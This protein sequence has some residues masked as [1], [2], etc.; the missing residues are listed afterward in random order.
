MQG[1]K[2]A[3]FLAAFLE[4]VPDLRQGL[5]IGCLA[6][7]TLQVGRPVDC[8]SQHLVLVPAGPVGYPECLGAPG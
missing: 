1:L 8:F 5:R 4:K 3:A 7:L 6:Y 2:G